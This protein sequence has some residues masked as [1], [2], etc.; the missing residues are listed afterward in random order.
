L[1][2]QK[3]IQKEDLAMIILQYAKYVNMLLNNL[4]KI[5]RI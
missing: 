1:N 5:Q 3:L 2:G 4:K